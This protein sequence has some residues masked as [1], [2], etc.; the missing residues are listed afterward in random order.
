MAAASKK[1]VSGQI[2]G[3]PLILNCKDQQTRVFVIALIVALGAASWFL[4]CDTFAVRRQ[5]EHFDRCKRD[6]PTGNT[7]EVAYHLPCQACVDCA[8]VYYIVLVLL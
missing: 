7:G 1:S 2:S 3:D 5:R 6:R 4:I 8:R